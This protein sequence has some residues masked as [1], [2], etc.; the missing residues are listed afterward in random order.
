MLQF[1][2]SIETAVANRSKAMFLVFFFVCLMSCDRPVCKYTNPIF[3]DYQ[4]NSKE[5]KQELI[6][7]IAHTK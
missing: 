1:S 5:Y 2:K 4:P 6:K 3:D 7:Q